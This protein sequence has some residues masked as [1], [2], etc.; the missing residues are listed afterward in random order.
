MSKRGYLIIIGIVAA[1]AVALLV[2]LVQTMSADARPVIASLEA[3]P[4]RLLPRGMCQITCSVAGTDD[5]ELN[6]GWS[7]EEGTISGKGATVTWT[8][9]NSSGSYNVTVIV[10]NGKGAAA[11]EYLTIEV[12]TNR[13]PTIASL[14]ASEEWTLPLG[15]VDIVCDASD[16]NGDDLSYEWSASAG[17]IA[18]TGNEVTWNA[19]QTVG[20]YDITVV[21]RDAHGA[22]D[23]RTL[24]VVVATEQPTVVGNLLI[25]TDG[26]GHCYLKPY[27]GGYYVGK[28][29]MYDIE[30]VVSDTSVGLS[31]E[32]SCTSGEFSGEGSTITW[33][34]PATVQ[35]V[36]V[37]VIVSNIGGEE[38]AAKS[39]LLNVVSC[40]TCT[41]GPCNTG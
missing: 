13:S 10:V 17:S 16:P 3:T 32:W 24:V 5:G 35:K 34:A 15:S 1:A 21:V 20:L 36:T 4:E 22:L 25:T 26:Y 9:P 28:E 8:A 29:Q 11:T 38:V 41:F 6:Y 23:T 39:L 30:C 37:T 19:P 12:K 27:A 7:A 33:T 40:S 18:G 31:Y 2:I 14:T